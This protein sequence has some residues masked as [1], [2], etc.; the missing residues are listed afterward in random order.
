MRTY[1]DG[2]YI[3]SVDMMM[4]FVNLFPQKVESLPMS[5]FE[6]VLEY[7]GWGTSSGKR[8]SPQ[9]VLDNP[10]KYKSDIERINHADLK[11]P[12]FVYDTLVVDGFHRI[13]RARMQNKEYINA[14]IFT[15]ETMSK[16]IIIEGN[17]HNDVP[18]DIDVYITKFVKEFCA[19]CTRKKLSGNTIKKVSM[20]KR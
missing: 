9:D 16:F 2:Q 6:S 7:K 20:K 10:K 8:Y 13:T 19:E 3:Y 1:S 15:A 14:Y 18:P 5:M 12:I 11:Y 17:N 4:S